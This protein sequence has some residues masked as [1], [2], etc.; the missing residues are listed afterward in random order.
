M[1]RLQAQGWHACAF[2]MVSIQSLTHQV[3]EAADWDEMKSAQALMFVSVNALQGWWDLLTEHQRHHWQNVWSCKPESVHIPGVWVT[4]LATAQAALRLGIP[5]DVICRPLSG[6]E[7]SESLWNEVQ[8]R[9]QAGDRVWIFR[10]TDAPQSTE[11][12]S[13]QGRSWLGDTLRE[14]G[15][16]VRYLATYERVSPMWTPQQQSEWEQL[17]NIA[18]AAHSL[19]WVFTS[20]Q[21][22]QE[23]VHR[24]PETKV[25]Q[26][27]VT[28]KVFVTHERM[29]DLAHKL[30]WVDVQCVGSGWMSL[31]RFLKHHAVGFHQPPLESST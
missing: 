17:C 29:V 15:V 6:L 4:G 23:A 28:S 21:L 31:V 3:V 10:G 30:G 12:S 8:G 18:F 22:M 20:A 11:S 9:V 19:I 14:R 2:P 24:M 26:I 5:A 16:K 27:L 13:G 7:D 25:R 1:Q